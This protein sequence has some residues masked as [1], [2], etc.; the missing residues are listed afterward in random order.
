MPNV[1]K[2]YVIEVEVTDSELSVDSVVDRVREAVDG[3]CVGDVEIEV[4]DVT[5]RGFKVELKPSY[6]GYQIVTIA[7][8][9][10]GSIEGILVEVV[11]KFT[12]FNDVND[13]P[14]S[15]MG[16][17]EPTVLD[18]REIERLLEKGVIVDGSNL[19]LDREE[20]E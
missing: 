15:D 1:D 19:G 13:T 20:D 18:A 9:L 7:D 5:S 16:D 17:D 12:G 4:L 6:L 3:F 11:D 10:R 14:S 2:N 8:S